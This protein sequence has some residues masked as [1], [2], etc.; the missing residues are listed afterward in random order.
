MLPW[1]KKEKA[2]PSPSK[3][4]DVPNPTYILSDYSNYT[5]KDIPSFGGA[6]GG[7]LS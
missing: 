3:G 5:N 7:F 2:S 4:G 6:W 1:Y